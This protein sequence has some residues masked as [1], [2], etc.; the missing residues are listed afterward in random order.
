MFLDALMRCLMKGATHSILGDSFLAIQGQDVSLILGLQCDGTRYRLQKGKK[1][2]FSDLKKEYFSKGVDRN[3]DCLVRS[4]MNM[5]VRRESKK[6]ESFVKLS[7]VYILGFFLFPTTSCSSPAWLP[8]YVDNLSTIGQYAWAQAIH[9]WMMDDVPLATARVKEKCAGKQSRI[10]YV[11]G[12]TMALIFW[13]Y[14]VTGNGK[15]I[16]FGRT[17]RILCYGVGSYK[18]QAAVSALIDS[19]EGKKF[20]PLMADRESEIELIGYGKVQRNNS[21]MVLETSDAMKST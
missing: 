21:L 11:R 13:F 14:E 2:T 15:K 9:K 7:L 6:E 1:G 18:K 19:L 8:Y 4:L 16:H 3:R 20:V 12:C 17:P 5:V 10:G